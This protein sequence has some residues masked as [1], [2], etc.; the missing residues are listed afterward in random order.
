V[1]R[2]HLRRRGL[3]I[4][5]AAGFCVI[6]TI[7]IGATVIVRK[8]T[9]RQQKADWQ[10]LKAHFVAQAAVQGALYKMRVMPNEAFEASQAA[11]AGILEP[12]DF[13]LQDVGTHRYNPDGT[14]AGEAIPLRV[15]DLFTGERKAWIVEGQTLASDQAIDEEDRVWQ[16]VIRLKAQGGI[17]DG[18]LTGNQVQQTREREDGTTEVIGGESNEEYRLEEISKTVEIKKIR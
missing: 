13:F 4:P 16:H 15:P 6:M 9:T 2:I 18:Y 17:S 12:L 8:N 1:R 3:A 11:Q 10:G 7:L 14:E 5:L